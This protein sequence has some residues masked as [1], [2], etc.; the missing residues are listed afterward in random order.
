MLLTLYFTVEEWSRTFVTLS[1]EKF[2][3][4]L[5]I[6]TV[7]HTLCRRRGSRLE[8]DGSSPTH[9]STLVHESLGP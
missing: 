2:G 7:T 9:G 8:R 3:V 4:Q 1:K 6:N 5:L